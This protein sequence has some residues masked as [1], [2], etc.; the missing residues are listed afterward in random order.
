MISNDL[1]YDSIRI[2]TEYYD[3][4]L[5]PFFD[6]LGDD[7]L[8]IGPAEGQELRGRDNIIK[9]FSSENHELT[10]TIGAIRAECISPNRSIHEV[11]L[12]YDIYTHYPTGNTDL[13]I[14][15]LHFSWYLNKVKN[16]NNIVSR[17]ELAVVHISNAWKYD[18]RDTIY[19][20]HYES[21]GL[22]VRIVSKPDSFIT[23]QSTD[24][25]VHRIP[26]DNLLYIETVKKSA[27]LRIH[28]TTD[29]IIING[30]L[31]QFEEKCPD[32]LLRI[33]SCYLINPKCVIRIDRFYVILSDKTR[34]SVPEKKY[35]AIKHRILTNYLNNLTPAAHKEMMH[36][37]C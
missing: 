17:W 33:H 27:K 4:N 14:Q 22:P 16:D 28:T 26:I 11:I 18:K 34:L 20:I 7:T 8:W 37:T 19:P 36:N 1:I 30:T 5:H 15:R 23:V 29:I 31:Q 35:T 9:A 2:I 13:H 10:F 6:C 25:C 3:N 21:L 32:D 24:M 12:Q